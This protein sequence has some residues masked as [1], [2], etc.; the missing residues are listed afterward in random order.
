MTAALAATLALAPGP[1]WSSHTGQSHPGSGAAPCQ[2][3]AEPRPGSKSYRWSCHAQVLVL[4]RDLR[5]VEVGATP[6]IVEA[7]A[8][9]PALPG[10]DGGCRGNELFTPVFSAPTEPPR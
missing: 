4:R 2:R 10:P 7:G 5:V 3:F 6:S 9:S 8:V 1:A